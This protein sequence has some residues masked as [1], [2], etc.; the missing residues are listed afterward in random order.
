MTCRLAQ[1]SLQVQ[2]GAATTALERAAAAEQREED[3]RTG[4]AAA[5]AAAVLKA[6][7]DAAIKAVGEQRARAEAAVRR[8]QLAEEELAFFSAIQGR[9]VSTIASGGRNRPQSAAVRSSSANLGALDTTP[10]RMI[11]E[12]SASAPETDIAQLAAEVCLCEHPCSAC[13]RLALWLSLFW[14][15][16]LE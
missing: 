5:P 11:A 8:A 14:H 12:R 10:L 4:G 1:E 16:T 9:N 15:T 3:L 2:R 6:E 13:D 7:L